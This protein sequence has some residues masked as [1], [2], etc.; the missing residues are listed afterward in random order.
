VTDLQKRLGG[1]FASEFP[2][3]FAESLVDS[4]MHECWLNGSCDLGSR[5]QRA[6]AECAPPVRCNVPSRYAE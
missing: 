3:Q 1:I 6:P 5:Q 4:R 2:M